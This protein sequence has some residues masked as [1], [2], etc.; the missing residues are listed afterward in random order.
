MTHSIQEE[1]II[2]AGNPAKIETWDAYYNKYREKG[3]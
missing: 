2:V 1:T 3:I